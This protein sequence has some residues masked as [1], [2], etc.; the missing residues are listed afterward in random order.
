MDGPSEATFGLAFEIFDRYGRLDRGNAILEKARSVSGP[1]FAFAKPGCLTRDLDYRDKKP[2]P[3]T[4]AIARRN[5]KALLAISKGGQPIPESIRTILS[6]ISDPSVPEMQC[7]RQI[8]GIFSVETHAL[9][10]LHTNEEGNTMLHLAAMGKKAETISYVLSKCP[11]LA[12]IRNTEVRTPLEALQ[13][14]ME[15]Q[16]TRREYGMLTEV[17]SDQFKGFPQHDIACLTALTVT[18]IFDLTKLSEQ[19]IVAV[20]STTDDMTRRDHKVN[21]IHR[22]LRLKYGCTYG[23]CNGEFLSPRMRDALL[24][25]DWIID[26]DHVLGYL[27]IS[28]RQNM[29]TNESMRQ[30]FTNMCL[31][32]ARCLDE[33]WLPNE[34]TILELCSNVT[35]ERPPVT[36]DYLQRN[37]TVAAVAM[38]IFDMAMPE[39]E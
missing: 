32:I 20:W 37:G 34:W 11:E 28:V 25:S 21:T 8:Q 19:D 14:T 17:R 18:E 15:L 39:D 22:K 29:R 12:C 36:R 23:K 31:H 33:N 30:G 35:S 2:H 7:V 26:N 27:A 3:Q 5:L 16:R 1:F 4:I 9:S 10:W 13:S 38:M 6:T 24:G